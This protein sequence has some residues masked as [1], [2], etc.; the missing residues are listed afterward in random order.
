MAASLHYHST[1]AVE[2]PALLSSTFLRSSA[3]PGS[4]LQR[5]LGVE[6]RL[7]GSSGFEL[8]EADWTKAKGGWLGRLE[9]VEL[10]RD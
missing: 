7:P 3:D 9:N 10:G 4:I 2:N 6:S 1:F 5:L 8:A